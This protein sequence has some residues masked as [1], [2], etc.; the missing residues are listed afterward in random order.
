[1]GGDSCA[2]QLVSYQISCPIQ[3]VEVS[4]QGRI[5]DFSKGGAQGNQYVRINVRAERAV[6]R[7]VWGHAP[8]GN[9]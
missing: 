6:A 5:Q 1:M 3:L 9:F 2:G 4:N 8:P 7:G